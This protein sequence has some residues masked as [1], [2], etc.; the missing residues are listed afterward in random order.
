M[1]VMQKS[2]GGP[3]DTGFLLQSLY[4]FIA[5][6]KKEKIEGS[7]VDDVMNYMAACKDEKRWKPY[8]ELWRTN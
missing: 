1:D 2:H 4:N 7:D 8:S 3:R 5:R 6:E